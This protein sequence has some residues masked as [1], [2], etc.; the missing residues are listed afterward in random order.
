MRRSRIAARVIRESPEP[1]ELPELPATPKSPESPEPSKATR[2]IDGIGPEQPTGPSRRAMPP[3]PPVPSPSTKAFGIVCAKRSGYTVDRD[4]ARLPIFL[5]GSQRPAPLRSPAA[6]RWLGEVS[7]R[8]GQRSQPSTNFPQARRSACPASLWFHFNTRRIPDDCHQV[9]MMEPAPRGCQ[10]PLTAFALPLPWRSNGAQADM[11]IST[12]QRDGCLT[13]GSRVASKLARLRGRR[14]RWGPRSSCNVWRARLGSQPELSG[15]QNYVGEPPMYTTPFLGRPGGDF[16]RGVVGL[17]S[18]VL[19]RVCLALLLRSSSPKRLSQ[20]HPRSI[21]RGQEGGQ[22][23]GSWEAAT[24]K[25]V[26]CI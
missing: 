7:S 21:P 15:Q 24:R 25:S 20:H 19:F 13:C 11:L 26:R 23:G 5:P 12:A 17:P 6:A 1:P 4:E 3:C 14:G 18:S 10:W 8:S 16:C 9:P 2:R 22:E